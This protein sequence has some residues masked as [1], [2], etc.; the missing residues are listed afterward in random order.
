MPGTP[1][2]A[3]LTYDALPGAGFSSSLSTTSFGFPFAS[4]SW[5]VPTKVTSLQPLSMYSSLSFLMIFDPRGPVPHAVL[6]MSLSTFCSSTQMSTGWPL[7]SPPKFLSLTLS[8]NA[9]GD[10]STLIVTVCVV[11]D[12]LQVGGG[13]QSR[14]VNVIVPVWT[15]GVVLVM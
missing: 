1:C 7:T 11:T 9:A 2:R 5:W 14:H 4:G 6:P 3:V 15:P 10:F 8:P 12:C 13:G